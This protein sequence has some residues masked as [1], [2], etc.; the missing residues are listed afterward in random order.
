MEERNI[1]SRN[2]TVE[3]IKS[4]FS[5][6]FEGFL[7]FPFVFADKLYFSSSDPPETSRSSQQHLPYIP[8]VN[9]SSLIYTAFFA[10][11][12]PLDLGLTC[13]FC[14]QLQEVMQTASEQK[15]AVIYFASNHEQKRANCAVLILA[16]LVRS[17][18]CFSSF[19]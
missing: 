9:D 8:F 18:P 16:Y 6:G 15:K 2:D 14:Q 19:P 10:D 3:L 11:F 17:K 7:R 1:F 4:K 5:L 12:G 13:K